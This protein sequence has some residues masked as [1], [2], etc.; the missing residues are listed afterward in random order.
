MATANDIQARA[1]QI[2]DSLN[3]LCEAAEMGAVQVEEAKLEEAVAI[4]DDDDVE[5]EAT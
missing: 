1:K 4:H 2:L 5:E 3:S